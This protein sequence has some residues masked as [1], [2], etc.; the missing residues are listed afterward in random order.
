M[1]KNKLKRMSEMPN[2]LKVI[3]GLFISSFVGLVLMLLL[4]LTV[5]Y[6]LKDTELLPDS[7]I[8]HF[9]FCEYAGCFL[10]GFIS[11]KILPFKG[12]ISGL[13]CGTVLT[14]IISIIVYFVS[15]RHLTMLS[16]VIFTGILVSV[17]GGI[18]SANIKRRK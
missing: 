6:I 17:A 3:L 14:V 18:V 13:V 2:C 9:L 1:L 10:C 11:N 7:L 12:I 5:S 4:T 8:L 16:L 15:S